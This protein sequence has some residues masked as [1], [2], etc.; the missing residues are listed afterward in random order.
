MAV[1]LDAMHGFPPGDEPGVLER[2]RKW[3]EVLAPEKFAKWVLDA[4]L[5]KVNI[6]KLS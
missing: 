5:M 2:P 6:G 3:M 1:V 4:D